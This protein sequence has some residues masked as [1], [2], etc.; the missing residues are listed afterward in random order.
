MA[1]AKEY[2]TGAITSIAVTAVAAILLPWWAVV[3]VLIG[4]AVILLTFLHLYEIS[5]HKSKMADDALLKTVLKHASNG[6][7]FITDRNGRIIRMNDAV[8]TLTDK[9]EQGQKV[10]NLFDF[11]DNDKKPAPLFTTSS[12]IVGVSSFSRTFTLEQKQHSA[13]IKVVP[14]PDTS[15]S[16]DNRFMVILNDISNERT[17]E[18]QRNEFISIT[19]HELRTPLT[20]AM[21]SLSMAQRAKDEQV[22]QDGMD[23]AQRSLNRLKTIINE[24]SVLAD[25]QTGVLDVD[26]ISVD[27]AELLKKQLEKSAQTAKDKNIELK[28]DI[29]PNTTPVFTSERRVNEIVQIYLENALKYTK[30][31]SVTV[32]AERSDDGG[33]TVAVQDTGIGIPVA[34]QDK[35]FTEF[36]QVDDV[37][38]RS[39]EGIGLGL[40]ITKQLAARLNGNVWLSS[41]PG[42]GSTFYLHIPQYSKQSKDA[43][44]VLDASLSDVSEALL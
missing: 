3:W 5:K 32:K 24:L 20:I 42:A 14:F 15:E 36:Y 17:L 44:K 6:A 13:H 25:A 9:A 38:S 34:D 39:T 37:L 8:N 28:I 35:V 29:N 22:R 19:S 11:T 26:I 18:D 12:P 40:Y 27:M 16:K 41:E 33:V 4:E 23:T 10:D 31:G 2:K 30:E 1:F 43:K 21:S 7:I